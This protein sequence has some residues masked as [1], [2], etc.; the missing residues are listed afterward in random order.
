MNGFDFY[1]QISSNLFVRVRYEKS[2]S[3]LFFDEGNNSVVYS[4]T[5]SSRSPDIPVLE[6]IV[7][8]L[9]PNSATVVNWP[10]TNLQILTTR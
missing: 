5:F 2:T 3:Y 7:G 9:S 8:Y 6:E 4:V 10:T 1:K